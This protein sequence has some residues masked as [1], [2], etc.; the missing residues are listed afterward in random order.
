MDATW[1]STASSGNLYYVQKIEVLTASATAYYVPLAV[2]PTVVYEGTVRLAEVTAKTLL[3]PG[4]WFYDVG[5]TRLYIRTSGND[6]P[7]GY[8]I[9]AGARSYGIYNVSKNYTT[10]QDLFLTGAK[11]KGVNVITSTGTIV[12]RITVG[13]MGWYPIQGGTSTSY[14][15]YLDGVTTGLVDNA[16]VYNVGAGIFINGNLGASDSVTIQNSTA[17][18]IDADG[19]TGAGGAAGS[20][21]TNAILQHNTAYNCSRYLWDAGTGSGIHF[22]GTKLINGIMRYNIS[23]NNGTAAVP[24]WGM[25]GDLSDSGYEIYGNIS[26]GNYGPGLTV[27]GA[28]VAKK[29]YNNITYHNG[30]LSSSGQ[31]TELYLMGTAQG[32]DIRNN[33]FV[34][35]DQNILVAI[36]GATTGHTIDY[37]LYYGGSATPFRWSGTAYDFADYKTATGQDGNSLNSDPAFIN[38]G[39]NDFRLSSTSPAINAG[40]NLGSTYQLGLDNIGSFPW[41]L[42]NQSLYGNWEIGAFVRPVRVSVSQ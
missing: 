10:F 36:V 18:D 9:E 3:L 14:G 27:G 17:H 29:V 26:Y 38:A 33:I 16:E 4:T 28:G 7:A 23:R 34:A 39:A 20:N 37:G 30:L 11:S 15:I 40:T 8:T 1:T 24:V 31:R 21:V 5:A 19:I 12:Q 41:T 13:N 25:G 32:A 6:D 22:V 2:T 42:V 35:D